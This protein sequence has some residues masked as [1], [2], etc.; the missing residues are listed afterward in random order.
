MATISTCIIVKNEINNIPNL[1]NDLKQFSDEIIIVD[2]GSDDGTAEWLQ[3]NQ[4]NVLKYEYFKWI[5]H[6]AAARNYSFSKATGDWIFWCDADDRISDELIN[7]INNIKDQLND[8]PYNAYYINYQF[9][10]DTFVPRLRLLKRS[11][12]PIW[13]GACHEYV[14]LTNPVSYSYDEFDQQTSLI[15]HQHEQGH[16]SRNIP[17]F[18]N[19]VLRNTDISAR[20]MYYF[21]NELRDNGYMDKAIEAAKIAI[22]MP[23]A[24]LF[25][26]WNAM[27]YTLSDYWR[28]SPD[29]A[30]EGI[31]N[32][33][34]FKSDNT[35]RGD[36]YYLLALLYNI[37]GKRE[38]FL[39][40]CQLAISTEVSDIYNY[41]MI[42]AYH[43]ILPA[44]DLYINIDDDEVKNN[45]I[46]L[47]KNYRNHPIV[48]EFANNN[49]II[50]N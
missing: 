11:D 35:M 29:L 25:D 3:Q 19:T 34:K 17:I 46:E 15:V 18:I 36:V 37:I 5:K 14:Y 12:G 4:D 21:S 27:L 50:F 1:V 30:I 2:T 33:N 23:E 22:F 43:Y 6:F 47:L 31:Y 10:K 39:E 13:T 49:N 8:K 42:E 24:C 16:P 9:G 28:S 38:E 40:N 44:I 41:G 26:C 20:D 48:S 7:D 32:I 45:M